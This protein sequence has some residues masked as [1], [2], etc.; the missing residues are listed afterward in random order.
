MKKLKKTL[1]TAGKVLLPVAALHFCTEAYHLANDEYHEEFPSK[2]RAAFQQEFGFPVRGHTKDIEEQPGFL[3]HI[4]LALHKEQLEKP[5][6]LNAV[7]II[8]ESYFKKSLKEQWSMLWMGNN[9]DYATSFFNDINISSIRSKYDAG[10]IQSVIHHEIKHIKTFKVRKEH[11]EFVGHWASLA[12]D[13]N[14]NSLYFGRTKQL[15]SYMGVVDTTNAAAE[16]SEKLGFV[17]DYARTNYREDIAVLCETAEAE[18]KK[19]VGWLY[20]LKNEKIAEKVKLAQE[21]NLIPPEFSEY[22]KV[23]QLDA[24][25]KASIYRMPTEYEAAFDALRQESRKFLDKH[26]DSVYEISIRHNMGRREANNCIAVGICGD[27]SD[28]K[29][30]LKAKFKDFFEYSAILRELSIYYTIKEGKER[31]SVYSQAYEKYL[32]GFRENDLNIVVN[33]VNDFLREKGEL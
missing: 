16:E 28:Y 11:P 18:P 9:R 23:L 26:P 29:L 20:D 30:G 13:E 33:G 17:S 12:K 25:L 24:M 6:E 27:A 22:V 10:Y 7:D 2:E 14:G 1:R 8:P 21:Y 32:Q 31:A 15:Q 4:A 3:S 5:F 19:F